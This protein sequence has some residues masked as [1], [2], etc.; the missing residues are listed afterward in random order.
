M[1]RGHGRIERNILDYLGAG[2][3]DTSTRAIAAHFNPD[4]GLLERLGDW[5]SAWRVHNASVLVSYR[6]AVRRLIDTGYLE[7]VRMGIPFEYDVWG[8]TT[9]T[10]WLDVHTVLRVIERNNR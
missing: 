6:R 10:D 4:A 2:H 1:S 8:G 5:P 7:R 9:R 3:D